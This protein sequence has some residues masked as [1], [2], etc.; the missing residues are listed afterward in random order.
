VGVC[1]KR[2]REREREREGQVRICV[3]L[4]VMHVCGVNTRRLT[5]AVL[6]GLRVDAGV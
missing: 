5:N 3:Y 4:Y 1:E 6:S 2:E